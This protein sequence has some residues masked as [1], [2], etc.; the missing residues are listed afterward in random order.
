MSALL[1]ARIWWLEME[2]WKLGQKRDQGM[3]ARY[4]DGK[5]SYGMTLTEQSTD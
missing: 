1:S 5:R 2:S 3:I 4:A